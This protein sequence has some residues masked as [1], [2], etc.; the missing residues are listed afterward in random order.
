MEP[1]VMGILDSTDGNPH[2]VVT[3][4]G[5]YVYDANKVHSLR[6]SGEAL[7]YCCSTETV[8]KTFLNF[9][10]VVLNHCKGSDQEKRQQTM[11]LT[12]LPGF[13]RKL[14]IHDDLLRPADR[15]SA[16]ILVAHVKRRIEQSESSESS[17]GAAMHPARA[18]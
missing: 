4:H 18:K 3:I 9:P 14:Y 13:D 15:L 1:I 8:K 5:G 12:A 17:T 2:R 10:K 7:D 11:T 16:G 6:L